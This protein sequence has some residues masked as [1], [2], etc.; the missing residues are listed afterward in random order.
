MA[1]K[2]AFVDFR[3]ERAQDGHGYGLGSRVRG[4]GPSAAIRAGA[5]AFLMR[6][7]GTDS[8][9]FA[10]TG[11]TRYAEGLA[12]IPAAALSNPDADQLARLLALDPATR[13]RVAL[14]CGWDGEYTSQNVIGEIT[15][16]KRPQEVVLIGG[17]LGFSPAGTVPG[18]G[19]IR[20]SERK[21]RKNGIE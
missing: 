19:S 20:K 11:M 7:A 1:G 3:M 14:D 8:H 21:C 13:V 16:S 12:P 9:R 17:H 10:H 15:G 5:A 4:A 2:I 18:S 6:S